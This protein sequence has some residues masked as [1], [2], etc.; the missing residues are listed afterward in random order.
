M[1]YK[2]QAWIIL[3]VAFAAGVTTTVNQFKVPPVLPALAAELN[4]DAVAG[5]WLMSVFSVAAVVLSIPAALLLDRLGFKATGMV[6]L[7]CVAAGSALGAMAP[8]ATVL[9]AGRLVEGISI[10][11]I[12][13]VAPALI[14]R[15]F[16]PHELGLPMGIW[17]TWVP[18]G[19]VIVLNVGPALQRA[20]GWRSVWWAGALLAL[21][22]LVP[23]ALL[24][25]PPRPAAPE[26]TTG[27]GGVV[28]RLTSAF[29]P[30]N[31]LLGLAFGSFAFAVISYST[32]APTYLAGVLGIPPA[33]ASSYASLIF[34]AGVVANLGAGWIMTRIRHGHALLAGALAATAVL[35]VWSFRLSTAVVIPYLLA[36]GL[37]SNLVPTAVFTLAPETV[38]RPAMAGVAM[39]VLNV[40]ANLGILLGP[41]LLGAA[42]GRGQ[43]GLAT[44]LLVAVSALGAAAAL[45][46]WRLAGRRP[47]MRRQT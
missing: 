46:A 42:V 21:A 25:R 34:V 3:T 9:L 35:F 18:A 1:S 10:A 26:A 40:V 28:S 39:A 14:S 33:T 45:L 17:A 44:G 32:W 31:W 29:S 5:G 20:L 12:A 36:V 13:V 37:V 38:R 8:T 22:I 23:Y 11:L 24:A 47:A 2:R 6:A 16:E 15:W 41:P 4:L 27:Q 30:G 7:G 19:S 43:W